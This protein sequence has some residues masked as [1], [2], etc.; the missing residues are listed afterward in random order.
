MKESPNAMHTEY[1]NDPSNF[2]QTR[3]LR[4]VAVNVHEVIE[5]QAR[6]IRVFVNIV[7]VYFGFIVYINVVFF[8]SGKF[9]ELLF[10]TV[11]VS[12][13]NYKLVQI[14]FLVTK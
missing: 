2:P 5:R 7:D 11:Y 3:G 4:K 10:T 8:F 12:K 13:L 6:S 1:L 9:L 14:I